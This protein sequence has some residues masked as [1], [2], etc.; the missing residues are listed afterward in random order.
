MILLSS[1]SILALN[2]KTGSGRPPIL[3]MVARPSLIFGAFAVGPVLVFRQD[4]KTRGQSAASSTAFF[5]EISFDLAAGTGRPG[6]ADAGPREARPP[7]TW[8]FARGSVAAV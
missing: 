7:A 5:I 1:S 4:T 6:W 2:S 3:A 8:P